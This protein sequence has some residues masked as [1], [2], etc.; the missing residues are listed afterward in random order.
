MKQNFFT[1]CNVEDNTMKERHSMGMRVKK[2][3][4]S[5]NLAHEDICFG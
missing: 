4:E 3:R 5:I 2:S 1:L